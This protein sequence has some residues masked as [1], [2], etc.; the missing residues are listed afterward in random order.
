[1]YALDKLEQTRTCSFKGVCWYD[2]EGGWTIC[3]ML[4]R[5][6]PRHSSPLVERDTFVI[7]DESHCRGADLQLRRGAV[8][9]LTLAPKVTKDKVMQAAGRLRQLMHGQQYVHFA[10][11][12]EVTAK[13]EATKS[14][15]ASLEDQ[16][17][18]ANTM[19]WV[20]GNTVQA[21]IDG[22][23]PWACQGIH[24]AFTMDVPERFIEPEFMQLAEMYGAGIIAAPVG[25]IVHALILKIQ[26]TYNGGPEGS[27]SQAAL[28]ILAA[29]DQR[30]MQYGA[31][32]DVLSS[33]A[34]A[35]RQGHVEVFEEHEVPRAREE[36]QEIFKDH[37]QQPSNH[38]Q[39]LDTG[40]DFHAVSSVEQASKASSQARYYIANADEQCER[41]LEKE[42]E[43]EQEMEIEIR[44]VQPQMEISWD[45][46]KAA[47]CQSLQE[48]QRVTGQLYSLESAAQH[49]VIGKQSMSCL[50]WAH[51]V[52]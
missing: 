42:L 23:V 46:R 10:G 31:G 51:T 2:S 41:E 34:L 38:C 13:I 11:S 26:D 25:D 50:P 6:W 29:V 15:R 52:W 32:H 43:K 45:F 44:Q 49:I 35:S 30:T 17:S 33:S 24:Y 12:T 36:E 22:L 9:L 5:E 16:I 4:G 40:T 20:M 3:N 8:G 48:L 1:M 37:D 39:R 18:A 14:L 7:Y 27:L 47:K 19:R 21:T 28:N